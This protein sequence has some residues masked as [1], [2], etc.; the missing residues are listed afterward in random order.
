MAERAALDLAAL[1]AATRLRR[2]SLTRAEAAPAAEFT[3]LGAALGNAAATRGSSLSLPTASPATA[4]QA[5]AASAAPPPPAAHPAACR[6]RQAKG[7]GGTEP[8]RVRCA[9]VSITTF[10]KQ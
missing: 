1:V 2:W 3:V 9:R 6:R 7:A 8:H 10:Y 5:A 4:V